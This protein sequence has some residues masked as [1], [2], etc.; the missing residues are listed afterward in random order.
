V[1]VFQNFGELADNTGV[2]ENIYTDNWAKYTLPSWRH[3]IWVGIFDPIF[4][5]TRPHLW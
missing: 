4:W 5:M 3:S 1:F 2:M